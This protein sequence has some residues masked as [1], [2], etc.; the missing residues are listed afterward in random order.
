[1]LTL[2]ALIAALAVAVPTSHAL[3]AANSDALAPNAVKAI[4]HK[5]DTYMLYRGNVAALHHVKHGKRTLTVPNSIMVK[6][7]RYTVVAVH[8]LQLF[9]RND[10]QSVKIKARHLETVE[11]PALFKDW[12]I[13][14]H[15]QL[16][17]AIA[18]KQTRKWLDK[19][20]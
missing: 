19:V 20:W 5:G 4:K 9:E 12:R 14:H 6:G 15:K 2:A 3:Q 18:D 17:V 10:V 16:R 1:M 11:E 8:E 13:C 7:K